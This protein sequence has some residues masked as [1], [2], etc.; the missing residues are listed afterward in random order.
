MLV[1]SRMIEEIVVI[2]IP[3]REDRIRIR[4]N[5]ILRCEKV[6]LGF[7]AAPDIKIWREEVQAEIDRE[8]GASQP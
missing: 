1:L 4:V 8:K 7:D 5:D 3:G 6:K 2:S